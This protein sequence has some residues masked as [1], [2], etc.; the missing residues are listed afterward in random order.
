MTPP[1]DNEAARLIEDHIATLDQHK[2]QLER[3]LAHLTGSADDGGGTQGGRG[4]RGQ[5]RRG[6]VRQ[7]Q[8]EGA[9]R[10]RRV[11]DAESGA[12]RAPRGARREEVIADLKANPGS[13]AADV[14][15]RIGI[16][17][18]HAQSILANLVKQG[19]AGEEGRQYTV[20]SD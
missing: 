6:P 10:G 8:T 5:G 15:R 17:P 2:G 3:A 11:Q 18:T 4:R 12:Q 9:A 14:A 1:E 20:V 16:N 7:S 19:V 13:K